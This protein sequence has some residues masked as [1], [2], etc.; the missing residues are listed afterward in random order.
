M[1]VCG[2]GRREAMPM[3]DPRAGPGDRL[4]TPHL[5]FFWELRFYLPPLCQELPKGTA[6]RRWVRCCRGMWTA[7]MWALRPWRQM[8]RGMHLR[9]P[10][11]AWRVSPLHLP[12]ASVLGF[13]SP[14]RGQ[15]VSQQGPPQVGLSATACSQTTGPYQGGKQ[16]QNEGRSVFHPCQSPW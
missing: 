3:A 8:H 4:E 13:S 15:P 7:S 12:S 10:R 14:K 11:Q 5:A 2:G 1:S 16:T 9:P 6:L